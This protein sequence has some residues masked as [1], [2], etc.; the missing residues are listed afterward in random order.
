MMYI[1]HY[2][3]LCTQD[4]IIGGKYISNVDTFHLRSVFVLV[5]KYVDEHFVAFVDNAEFG[6]ISHYLQRLRVKMDHVVA[7]KLLKVVL[8]GMPTFEVLCKVGIEIISETF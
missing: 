1:L 3:R 4:L 5:K 8:E 6:T 2:H 7:Q